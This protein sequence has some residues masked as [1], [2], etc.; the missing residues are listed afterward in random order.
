MNEEYF[1][2]YGCEGV[3]P[4]RDFHL[5][6]SCGLGFCDMCGVFVEDTFFCDDCHSDEYSEHIKKE[7]KN[8]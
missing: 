8:E 3:V 7:G 1:E 6:T 4:V 2:C 5:C